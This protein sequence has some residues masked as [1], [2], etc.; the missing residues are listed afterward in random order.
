[1]SGFTHHSKLYDPITSLH[2]EASV[3]DSGDQVNTY[4]ITYEPSENGSYLQRGVF[5]GVCG[6]IMSII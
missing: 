2:F 4:L 6:K 1:M 5:L 3:F